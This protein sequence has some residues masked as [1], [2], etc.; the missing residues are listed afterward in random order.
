M[1]HRRSITPVFSNKNAVHSIFNVL[2]A[3]T[4]KCSNDVDMKHNEERHV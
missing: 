1:L 2:N 4:T 3:V